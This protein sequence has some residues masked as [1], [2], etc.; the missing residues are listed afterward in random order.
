MV[1]AFIRPIEKAPTDTD[2]C[3]F[4]Q[5]RFGLYQI[6]CPCRLK[7]GRWINAHLCDDIKVMPV[8]W[9]PRTERDRRIGRSKNQPTFPFRVGF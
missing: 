2:L 1:E 7:A 8:G 6:P 4:G 5:D 9:K 3:V